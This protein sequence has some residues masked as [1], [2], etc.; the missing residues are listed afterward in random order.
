MEVGVH[1]RLDEGDQE[2]VLVAN[3]LDFVV[4][5]EDFAF[6]KTERFHDVLVGVRVDGFF[7]CLAQQKLA[8][9]WCCDVA[10][11]A[12]HNVVGRQRVCSDK[13]AQVALDDAAL[14]IR[15]AVG[16]FPQ[17]DVPR[18]VHF[19]RHPV[20]GASGQVFFPRPLVLERHQL[21][22]VGLAV[23]DAFVGCVHAAVRCRSGGRGHTTAGADCSTYDLR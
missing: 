12:Q 1:D 11:G 6:I 9:L 18:H 7:K 13:E 3:R 23:D 19:L 15:Q 17:R 5:V 20:I 21:V 4:G 2:L 10:I 22:D 16:V 14:V 8:A